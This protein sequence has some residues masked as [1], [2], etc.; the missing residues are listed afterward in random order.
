MSGWVGMKETQK[1]FTD[2]DR[3]CTKERQTVI[4]KAARKHLVP[5]MKSAAGGSPG[6]AGPLLAKFT[7][8]RRGKQGAVVVGPRTGKKRAWY[9]AFFI[10]GAQVHMIG[11]TKVAG[12][13]TRS[14][15]RVFLYNPNASFVAMGPVRHPGIAPNPF[16]RAGAERGY[17]AF[18]RTVGAAL[19][20]GKVSI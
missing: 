18:V 4:L 15:G 5:G 9:R 6:R 14:R 16:V 20:E 3:R 13:R 10:A 12:K 19:F 17:P 7:T 11:G 8:A 2:I 1:V